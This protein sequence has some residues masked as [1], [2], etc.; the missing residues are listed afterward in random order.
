MG[1][2]LILVCELLLVRG[3]AGQEGNSGEDWL[4]ERGA[5]RLKTGS[6]GWG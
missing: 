3:A 1:R 2:D 4:R 6:K 5:A